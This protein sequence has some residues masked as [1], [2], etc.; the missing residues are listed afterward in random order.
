MLWRGSLFVCLACAF[1]AAPLALAGQRPL[2]VSYDSDSALRGLDVLSRVAPLHLAKIAPTD[3]AKLRARPG[4][5][6]VR[7][8][9]VRRRLGVSLVAAPRRAATA[10]WQFTATR[11]NLV[12]LAIQR[13]AADITIAVVDTGADVTAPD[14]A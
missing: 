4:I 7:T 11:S 6:W 5:R 1:L 3:A 9:V 10:E 14:I 12:P 2:T 13:A 8:T